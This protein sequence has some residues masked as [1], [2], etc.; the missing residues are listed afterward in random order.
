MLIPIITVFSDVI[1]LF[2]FQPPRAE[3]NTPFHRPCSEAE[4]ML[5]E[6]ECDRP[7]AKQPAPRRARS[8]EPRLRL[9]DKAPSLPEGKALARG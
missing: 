1:R 6:T 9:P 3:G 2:T 4:R 8:V 5:V 7:A